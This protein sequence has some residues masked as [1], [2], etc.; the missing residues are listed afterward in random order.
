MVSIIPGEVLVEDERKNSKSCPIVL[1]A[2]CHLGGVL[3]LRVDRKVQ[4]EKK[5]LK[6]KPRIQLCILRFSFI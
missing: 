6:M 2:A 4:K 3:P 1:A 5:K